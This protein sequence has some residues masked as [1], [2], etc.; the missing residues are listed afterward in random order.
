MSWFDSL[1]RRFLGPVGSEAYSGSKAFATPATSE[2]GY[3]TCL[4]CGG[5]W[6]HRR[7]HWT[8]YSHAGMGPLCEECYDSM[9]PEERW[10][11]YLQLWENWGSP[12]DVDLDLIKQG[13][14]LEAS[15]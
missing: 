5:S 4:H 15:P 8:F 12:G 10:P 13:I 14:G 7:P 11:Y 3:G 2:A 9:T 1:R 6:A